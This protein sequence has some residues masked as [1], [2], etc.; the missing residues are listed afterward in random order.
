MTIPTESDF[1]EAIAA[2]SAPL[3]NDVLSVFSSDMFLTSDMSSI[4]AKTIEGAFYA[5][6][7]NYDKA[8]QL[9]ASEWFFRNRFVAS[10]YKTASRN[11]KAAE[12]GVWNQALFHYLQKCIKQRH[13]YGMLDEPDKTGKL[14]QEF[15]DRHQ[16]IYGRKWAL[17]FLPAFNEYFHRENA[18]SLM[19]AQRQLIEKLHKEAEAGIAALRSLRDLAKSFDIPRVFLSSESAIKSVER[20]AA[21]SAYSAIKALTIPISRNDHT[22]R[23][24]LL[25]WRIWC[26]M[27]RANIRDS[28]TAIK[29]LLRIDGIENPIDDRSIDSMLKKFRE[30]EAS[31]LAAQEANRLAAQ[32]EGWLTARE[33]LSL[34]AN[35]HGT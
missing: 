34:I 3:P 17:A 20:R 28:P 25:V 9:H 7:E 2:F 18:V 8:V 30:E 33:S 11:V 23:E 1:E 13:E 26:G 16:I 32:E 29:K 22:A 19:R 15:F 31:R 24:R 27:K 10:A 5:S 6:T 35:Q 4:A 14:V 12:P 21:D